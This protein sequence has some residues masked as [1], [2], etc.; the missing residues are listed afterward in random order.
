MSK[1]QGGHSRAGPRAQRL[2]SMLG[3]PR[4]ALSQILLGLAVVLKAVIETAVG[5]WEVGS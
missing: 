4:Q 5:G 3:Q 2:A 1:A